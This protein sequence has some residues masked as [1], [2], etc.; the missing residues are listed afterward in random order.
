MPK[1][2]NRLTR[3][4]VEASLAEM[5]SALAALPADP[6]DTADVFDEAAEVEKRLRAR[7]EAQDRL[8][9]AA[10]ELLRVLRLVWANNQ[11]WNTLPEDLKNEIAAAL[12][13]AGEQPNWPPPA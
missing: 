8:D 12:V 10:P 5:Y 4:G 2:T 7:L 3:E 13:T 9:Q 1:P 11:N 6:N